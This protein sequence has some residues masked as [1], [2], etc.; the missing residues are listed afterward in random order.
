MSVGVSAS[1]TAGRTQDLTRSSS[2]T[3]SNDLPGIVHIEIRDRDAPR[4]GARDQ[5]PKPLAQTQSASCGAASK[6]QKPT[7]T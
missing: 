4:L 7:K 1:S 6:R 3:A 2:N 5:L